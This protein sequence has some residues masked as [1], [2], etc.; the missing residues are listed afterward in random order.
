[1]IPFMRRAAV[2]SCACDLPYC[3]FS[4]DFTFPEQAVNPSSAVTQKDWDNWLLFRQAQGQCL[5]WNDSTWTL[6]WCHLL[7]D[8]RIRVAN[9]GVQGGSSITKW[10]KICQVLFLASDFTNLSWSV[11]GNKQV[12]LTNELME[13][14]TAQLSLK[15]SDWKQKHFNGEEDKGSILRLHM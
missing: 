8:T 15:L 10:T 14:K 13:R 7:F 11:V 6:L 3:V 2:P 1:M 12:F 4:H 9:D 5:S